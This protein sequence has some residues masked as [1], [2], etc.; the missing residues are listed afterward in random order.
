MI[1]FLPMAQLSPFHSRRCMQPG[2]KR[3][4]TGAYC[5]TSIFSNNASESK[6]YIQAEA[7]KQVERAIWRRQWLEFVKNGCW[8]QAIMLLILRLWPVKAARSSR[9]LQIPIIT[10]MALPPQRLQVQHLQLVASP[11]LK[12]RLLFSTRPSTES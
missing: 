2:L 7:S 12:I 10:V 4:L 8:S 6:M 9:L 3:K 5:E 1:W 11:R